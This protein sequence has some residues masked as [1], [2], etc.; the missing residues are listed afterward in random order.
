MEIQGCHF[1]H[2]VYFAVGR[3]L[4]AHLSGY[5]CLFVAEFV[6][7]V[8]AVLVDHVETVVIASADYCVAIRGGSYPEFVKYG[9]VLEH[10]A[11][12][13]LEGV[14]EADIENWFFVVADVP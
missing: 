12:F 5:R 4:A 8:E 6:L 10:F 14:V 2:I 1:P 3:T 9:L 11:E 7:G 13:C